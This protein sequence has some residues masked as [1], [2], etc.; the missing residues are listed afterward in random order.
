MMNDTSDADDAGDYL[1]KHYP[2]YFGDKGLLVIHTDKKGDVSKKDLEQARQTARE[3][4]DETNP[5]NAIVSVLMLREGWDVQNVTVVVGLRPYT[6]KANILPE[7]TI[8]RGL[9]LMFR[10]M[11]SDYIERLDVI[12]NSSFISFVED[13]E[14]DEGT[15]F[16]SFQIGKDKLEI[17]TIMPDTQKADKDIEIPVLSPILVRKK[18]I[19]EEIE[20]IDVGTLKAPRLPKKETKEET[21]T[22]RYDGYDFLTLQKLVERKYKIPMAQTPQEV[23]SYY[24]KEIAQN[25]KLPSQFA[26]IVPKISQFLE[27]RAFGE[28]VSLEDPT[29]LKA[30]SSNVAQYVVIQTFVKALRAVII[31]ERTP[32]LTGPTRKLSETE[33]FPFSRKTNVASKCIFNRVPCDNDFELQFSEFLQSANDVVKY[34]KLPRR[35]GFSIEY[36]D[37]VANLR[38]YEPDFVA[39]LE[40]GGNYIVE[41]KGLQDID[42]QHK[43]IAAKIWCEYATTLTGKQWSYLKVQQQDFLRLEPNEFSD[44]LVLSEGQ[45][46]VPT[47]ITSF[48]EIISQI[49][50]QTLF[51]NVYRNNE[52]LA[53]LSVICRFGPLTVEQLSDSIETNRELTTQYLCVLKANSLVNQKEDRIEISAAGVQLLESMRLNQKAM[54]GNKGATK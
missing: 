36:T 42:V 4:D 37:S 8:G 38:Y 54:Q 53:L 22:F 28:K 9:R 7:Q 3:V 48:D 16:G 39:V 51:L 12:G 25:L 18:S 44:L 11:E 50:K 15:K 10:G 33:P 19:S 35:F 34:S 40:N 32:E 14:R 13:L 20:S 30:I 24:A 6:A 43:D 2:D 5:V 49:D 27:E 31:E 46:A 52:I 47:E 1:Q 29:I 23:I 45:R 26:H 41:T 21:E 17:V